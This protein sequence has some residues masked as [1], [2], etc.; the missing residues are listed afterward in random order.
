MR[1]YLTVSKHRGQIF[2]KEVDQGTK[3]I[4]LKKIS[5]YPFRFWGPSNEETGW[6]DVKGH[7]LKEITTEGVSDFSKKTKTVLEYGYKLYGTDKLD[8]QYI[9][10]EF[11]DVTPINDLVTT[12]FFDIET[13]R[14]AVLGYS[15]SSDALN[16]ILTISLTIKNKIYYWATKDLDT[17]FCDQLGFE[18]F[19]F[20]HEKHMLEHFMKFIRESGISIFSGWNIIQYDIPYLFNRA[21]RLEL[22]PNKISPF[23]KVDSRTFT[24]HFN[25]EVQTYVIHGIEILD[26]LD[27][28]KKFTYVTRDNYQLNT[29]AKAELGKEKVNYDEERNLQELY[30]NDFQK[31]TEYNIRDSLLVKELDD[32]LKLLDLCKTIAYKANVNFSDALGTVKMWQFYLYREMLNQFMVPPMKPYNTDSAGIIGG[33][34][35]DPLIGMHEWVVSFDLASLYPHNQMGNNIS[36]DMLLDDD[37]LPV[38]ILELRTAIWEE[39]GN[40][41][42]IIDALAEKRIDLS[43]LKQYNIC[44]TPNLHFFKRDTVGFI[45]SILKQVYNDRSIAKKKMLEKKQELVNLKAEYPEYEKD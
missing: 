10:E 35:K 45:P 17:T 5:K 33:F 42:N 8:Y 39:Y 18:F 2:S 22:D 38:E 3:E 29:V 13:A 34:V 23:L 15:T 6:T 12:G 36:P 26:Y 40:I 31:F 7:P 19:W 1:Q 11:K 24:D 32:K 20:E 14:D 28:Y 25:Q 21:K 43:L 37:E 9:Y 44:M 4:H 41:E 16:E 27:L 30:E